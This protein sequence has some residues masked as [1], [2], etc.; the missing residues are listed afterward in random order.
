MGFGASSMSAFDGPDL[1][2][3]GWQYARV[4]PGYLQSTS[5]LL[6]NLSFDGALRA[7]GCNEGLRTPT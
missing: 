7:A 6:E 1:E 2:V 3:Y 4:D 5:V